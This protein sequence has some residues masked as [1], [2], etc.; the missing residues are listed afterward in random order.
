MKKAWTGDP[1]V[2]VSSK[3]TTPPPAPL[4]QMSPPAPTN[5]TSPPT[6][7]DQTPPAAPADQAPPAAPAD[8]APPDQTGD[9][10]TSI[11]LSSAKE[12]MTKILRHRCSR[13]AIIGNDS[14]EVDQIINCALNEI[15]SGMLTMTASW[16]RSGALTAQYEKKLGEQLK[17]SEDRHAEE[18]KMAEAKYIEQLEAAEKQNPELLEQKAKMDEELKQH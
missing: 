13:E 2:P 10:L 11:M 17:A 3:E 9:A 7:T 5:Q 16:R 15:A 12:R 8:Q 14:V 18:L 4:D 1:L 6:P